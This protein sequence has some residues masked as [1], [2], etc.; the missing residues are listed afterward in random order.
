MTAL[1]LLV[2]LFTQLTPSNLLAISS[3]P[4]WQTTEYAI[5]FRSI[6]GL[7]EGTPVLNNGVTVGYVH[8]IELASA[9]ES[10]L[11]TRVNISVFSSHATSV[12]KKSVALSSTPVSSKNS[13][14]PVTIVELLTPQE[15]EPQR[16]LA[17]ATIPGFSTFEE[18][19]ASDKIHF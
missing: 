4:E 8:S 19:W 5:H 18:F 17:G 3:A 6:E 13:S 12:S 1:L 11:R 2:S 7:R 14:A 16:L 15:H 10:A 9:D